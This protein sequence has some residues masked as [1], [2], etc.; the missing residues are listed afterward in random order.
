MG[1][2]VMIFIPSFIKIGSGIRQLIGEIHRYIHRQHGDS[3]SLPLFQNKENSLI[4][5]KG[6]RCQFFPSVHISLLSLPLPLQVPSVNV[7]LLSAWISF[8]HRPLSCIFYPEDMGRIFFRNV[9]KNLPVH[10]ALH[11]LK[12]IIL[13]TNLRCVF[14][15]DDFLR[16]TYRR[17]QVL[18]WQDGSWVTW[19][20]FGRKRSQRKQDYY[21]RVKTLE[22]HVR[23]PVFWLR[24]EPIT[25]RIQAQSLNGTWL[26][27][28]V[29]YHCGRCYVNIAEK[30]VTP[31]TNR[32]ETIEVLPET[33]TL[34]I[35]GP[36]CSW[37][38]GWRSLES[39]SVKY[40]HESRR[41]LTWEWLCWQEPAATVNDKPIFSSD[42]LW[43]QEFSWRKKS[44]HEYQGAWAPTEIIW[45]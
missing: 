9:D 33:V 41:T 45:R 43:P 40:G 29:W 4:N 14:S 20:G 26:C 6:G 15:S 19:K 13:N 16:V 10:I 27:S 17:C 5:K 18:D 23:Q 42:R 11:P 25:S 35:T 36:P 39:E 31:A 44:G 28:P 32:R 2:G 7:S 37:G 1:S 38:T 12:T 24:F 22:T 3:I 8:S 30:H 34:T 21:P